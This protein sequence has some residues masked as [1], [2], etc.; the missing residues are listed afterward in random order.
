MFL[1]SLRSATLTPTSSRSSM[2]ESGSSGH[3]SNTRR[4][5]HSSSAASGFGRTVVA[6]SMDTVWTGSVWRMYM[7]NIRSTSRCMNARRST[8]GCTRPTCT[9]ATPLSRR[10]ICARPSG[11]TGQ[12]SSPTLTLLHTTNEWQSSSAAI[13]ACAC[14]SCSSVGG[15]T[16]K[17]VYMSTCGTAQTASTR[18]PKAL[19]AEHGFSMYEGREVLRPAPTFCIHA[20][21]TPTRGALYGTSTTVRPSMRV[22]C[23]LRPAPSSTTLEYVMTCAKC[24]DQHTAHGPHNI[25][26]AHLV[27]HMQD[28]QHMGAMGC[29][30]HSAQPINTRLHRV[31]HSACQ[32]H[33]REE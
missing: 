15:C 16:P 7:N 27:H 8:S 26:R 4:R 23:A 20:W 22:R 31:M 3:G 29:T 14:C 25:D 19:G 28:T 18:P 2:N 21:T 11:C 6:A 5:D 12:R 30:P 10:T 32:M 13:I 24:V 1:H 17:P 33:S 9:C